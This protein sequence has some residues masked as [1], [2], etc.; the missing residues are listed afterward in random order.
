MDDIEIRR[1]VI[2]SFNITKVEFTDRTYI[3]NGVLYIRNNIENDILKGEELIKSLKIRVIN[4]DNRDTYVNSIM[5][6][7]PIAVKV[8]GRLGEGITHVLTGVCVMLTGVYEDGTQVS[9]FGSSE[10]ILKDKVIFNRAG[11]PSDFD[12]IIHLDA[13]LK[14]ASRL[15]PDSAHRATDRLVDEIRSFLKGMNGRLCDER[16]EYVDRIRPDKKKVVII[17]QVAGQGAMYD[18]RLFGNEPGGFF[19]G[20]SIIDMGNMPILVSPNEYR[21]GALRAMH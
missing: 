21:D 8:L 17:K 11:T 3:D 9:E 14:E 1:L 2:K 20:H 5:D 12:I 15:G 7:S 16:H 13:T 18:T 19:G 10:G 4:P 6:F